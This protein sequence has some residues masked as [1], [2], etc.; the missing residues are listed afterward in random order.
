MV[1]IS[2]ILLRIIK[3]D[4]EIVQ[5]VNIAKANIKPSDSKMVRF[6]KKINKWSLKDNGYAGVKWY[7]DKNNNDKYKYQS[8]YQ[9]EYNREGYISDEIVIFAKP[10]KLTVYIFFEKGTQKIYWGVTDSSFTFRPNQVVSIYT[11]TIDSLIQVPLFVDLCWVNG[12]NKV[13]LYRKDFRLSPVPVIG[14]KFPPR[15]FSKII[16]FSDLESPIPGEENMRIDISFPYTGIRKKQLLREWLRFK[17]SIPREVP[18]REI[19]VPREFREGVE[20]RGSDEEPLDVRR[21]RLVRDRRIRAAIEDTIMLD[22][23]F[24]LD[25][26]PAPDENGYIV[27]NNNEYD[28]YD[29][30][31]PTGLFNRL[32]FDDNGK[33]DCY[34]INGQ[35]YKFNPNTENKV[36]NGEYAFYWCPSDNTFGIR[37]KKQVNNDNENNN[38]DDRGDGDGEGD[39]NEHE[40]AH[41]VNKYIYLNVL[42]ENLTGRMEPVIIDFYTKSYYHLGRMNYTEDNIRNKD[43]V[44]ISTQEFEMVWERRLRD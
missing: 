20:I 30:N 9:R 6:G 38:N 39:N 10:G 13:N 42:S 33:T 11:E 41:M 24:T 19:E 16:N 5:C 44:W 25:D 4:S 12:Y 26:I 34:A 43:Q 14:L 31:N 28:N 37:Y 3:R 22:N 21:D 23:H 35:F 18:I 32:R 1:F 40:T 15:I 27:F 17:S 7:K 29:I 36:M 2:N 8:P